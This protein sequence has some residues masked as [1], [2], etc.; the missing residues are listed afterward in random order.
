[1]AQG[2]PSTRLQR[3][4]GSK[5]QRRLLL[6]VRLLI[7][8]LQA[9]GRPEDQLIVSKIKAVVKDCV[10]QN[11]AGYMTATP[12]QETLECRLRAVVGQQMFGE[13]LFLVDLYQAKKR[14]LARRY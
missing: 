1:M 5:R 11:R 9:T 10:R 14:L 3:R 13:A 4:V 2:R 12:L 6:S 7:K 8:I